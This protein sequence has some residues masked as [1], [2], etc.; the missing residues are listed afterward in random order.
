MPD[1]QIQPAQRVAVASFREFA[2]GRIPDHVMRYDGEGFM[3]HTVQLAFE[4][5]QAG[6]QH[7]VGQQLYAG[8]KESSKYHSQV[9]WNIQQGY[10]H[11][12]PVVLEAATDGYV[13]RGGVGRRYRLTD[14][15][16]YVMHDGKPF[17]VI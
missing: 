2:K 3:H 4:A 1:E 5:F 9:D 14:V 15:E 12:F 7:T 13:V 8:I 6:P 17:R 16:L 11:P 10:G